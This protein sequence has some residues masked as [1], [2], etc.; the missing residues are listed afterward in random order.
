M[1]SF[2]L[3]HSSSYTM[4][5]QNWG[6]CNC[7]QL[8]QSRLSQ[9]TGLKIGTQLFSFFSLFFLP[10]GEEWQVRSPRSLVSQQQVWLLNTPSALIFS[11]SLSGIFL[12][13]QTL[14]D[15]VMKNEELW[16]TLIDFKPTEERW[17]CVFLCLAHMVAHL[18]FHECH[19]EPFWSNI[20]HITHQLSH[21][22]TH[23]AGMV[24]IHK[25][26]I[27]DNTIIKHISREAEF[28]VL[29]TSIS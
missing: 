7:A 10:A 12:L 17:W 6:F 22:H 5:I 11:T 14:Q 8:K 3:H 19:S 23:T 27:K 29:C 26:W 25:A 9:R 2:Y 18:I 13:P 16:I 15:S 20:Q 1:N 21:T 28:E 24:I 4:S